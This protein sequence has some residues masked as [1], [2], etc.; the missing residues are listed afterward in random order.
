MLTVLRRAAGI[1]AAVA[2]L[3]STIASPLGCGGSAKRTAGDDAGAD[4]AAAAGDDASVAD[5]GSSLESSSEA[6]TVT[7]GAARNAACT[8]TSQQTG[9]ITNTKHGR[10]D[11]TLVYVL[12]VDGSYACNGDSSHV[13]LQ[14]EVSGLVYDV[15]IDIGATGDEVGLYQ[16]S[17]A[18]PDG[19]WA[20]GWHGSDSLTYPTLGVK[21]SAMPLAAPSDVASQVQAALESTSQISVFCTSYTQG[22]GCHDVHYENGNGDDG[23]IVLDPTAASSPILFF[24]FSTQNF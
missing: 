15:A 6:A 18:M 12:P 9:T 14:I 1:G 17:M 3:S 19:A 22:N 24:R 4:E 10:L 11:G 5:S 20:E 16:T 23:A 7:D 8:P 21:S 2:V 13:H